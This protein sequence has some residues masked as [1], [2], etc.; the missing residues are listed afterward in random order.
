MDKRVLDF[1]VVIGGWVSV[2]VTA[3]GGSGGG[4]TAIRGMRAL[5]PL[6]SI[7]GYP[8]LRVF[9]NTTIE[10]MSMVVNV[11]FFL[12]VLLVVLGIL[13]VQRYAGKLSQRCAYASTLQLNF[14]EIEFPCSDKRFGRQ[15]GPS[16]VCI[17]TSLNGVDGGFSTFNNVIG[18]AF[19]IYRIFTLRGWVDL[20]YQIIDGTETKSGRYFTLYSRRRLE[21][22]S[23]RRLCSPR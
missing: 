1:I 11:L 9:A 15:C 20:M 18:A 4:V 17:S 23:F 10:S 6:R 8:K 7:S 2:G 14:D 22:S 21:P 3:A 13:G 19:I 12:L 5:R 16:Q